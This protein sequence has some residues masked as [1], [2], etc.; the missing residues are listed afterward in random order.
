MRS[1]RKS[2]RSKTTGPAAIAPAVA[3]RSARDGVGELGRRI[4]RIRVGGGSSSRVSSSTSNR[5]TSRPNS[6]GI[7]P[8]ASGQSCEISPATIGR[9]VMPPPRS[10][11][12]P[13]REPD[14]RRER[15]VGARGAEERL[16]EIRVGRV[17]GVVVPVEAAAALGGPRQHRQQN[18]AEERVVA[19]IADA[20]VRA[21]EDRR[22]RLALQIVDRVARIR[23]AAKRRRLLVDEA[24]DERPVLVERRTVAR[25]VLL[26]RERHLRA[27]LGGER[28]RGR[29]RAGDS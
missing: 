15:D 9:S 17:E 19:G 14:D 1:G 13:G 20:G 27:A 21:R 8:R 12:V 23:E 6:G 10:A 26:E 25:R 24:A 11:S 29:R 2:R 7:R 18:R 16:L 5:S 3:R 28:S 22:G 4:G